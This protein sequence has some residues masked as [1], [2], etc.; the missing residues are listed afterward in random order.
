MGVSGGSGGGAGSYPPQSFPTNTRWAPISPA[1][2]A[3]SNTLGIG[4]LRLA[5]CYLP[6]CI[7]TGIGAEITGAGD[8]GSTLRLA[9]YA[10]NG[11]G[12]P[13]AV[14]LDPGTIAAD[15]AT[16][17]EITVAHT[18]KPGWYHL[19]AVVQNDVVTQPTVRVNGANVVPEGFPLQFGIV[20]PVAGSVVT[21]YSLLGVAGALPVWSGVAIS[22]AAAP[23]LWLRF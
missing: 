8:A 16:A 4:T 15:S 21:G 10:D 1:A 19:G 13:G 20:L 7:I 5:P 22:G 3:T 9:V 23:R 2:N 6:G 11:F 12:V 18:F 14:E 17:Q